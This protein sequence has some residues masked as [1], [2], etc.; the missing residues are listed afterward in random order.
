MACYKISSY[1]EFGLYCDKDLEGK[2]VSIDYDMSSRLW[3]GFIDKVL[4]FC[5]SDLKVHF[6]LINLLCK[7]YTE[8]DDL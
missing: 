1:N 2:T 8:L 3:C 7:L 5:A 4:M 6:S